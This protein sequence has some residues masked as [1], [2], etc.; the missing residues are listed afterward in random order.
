MTVIIG[1]IGL[2][3]G[4]YTQLILYVPIDKLKDSDKLDFML[5]IRL[6]SNTKFRWYRNLYEG[7]PLCVILVKMPTFHYDM[8]L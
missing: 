1:F 8:T 5:I 4:F 3:N 6:C 2:F 7:R